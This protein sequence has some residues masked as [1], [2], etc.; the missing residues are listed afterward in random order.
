MFPASQIQ[1]LA[2]G[3][4]ALVPLGWML[5]MS[6]GRVS[7]NLTNSLAPA[8]V[9]FIVCGITPLAFICATSALLDSS[10]GQALYR[11]SSESPRSG[12]SKL[13][14]HLWLPLWQVLKTA[15]PRPSYFGNPWSAGEVG[16]TVILALCNI[17]W[18]FVPIVVRLNSKSHSHGPDQ[19]P[20]YK[21]ARSICGWAGWAGLWDAGLCILFV[22]RENM[23]TK[24][25]LGSEAGQYHRV[26]RFHIGLGYTSFLMM[27]LHSLF[28]L[29][30]FIVKNTFAEEMFP[31]V[32]SMGYWNFA[33]L[34]SW[35]ALVGMVATSVYKVRRSNYRVFYWT[36]QL[37][38][39]FFFFAFV[40]MGIMAAYPVM[41]PC[42][43]FIYDRLRP[44][45]LFKRSTEAYIEKT[46]SDS[47]V[48]VQV[49]I[50]DAWKTTSGYAPGDC[51]ASYY[52]ESPD[53]LTL[54]IKTNGQW[55]TEVAKLC[56][57]QQDRVKVPV[58]IDGPF[59]S[60]STSYL[61]YESLVLVAGGSGVAALLPFVR[62]YAV[63]GP[64]S[65]K[66]HLVWTAKSESDVVTFAQFV[67]DMAD[68]NSLLSS[69]V[70]LSLHITGKPAKTADEAKLLDSNGADNSKDFSS[71]ESKTAANLDSKDLA[72]TV[73]GAEQPV[74]TGRP[75]L[76]PQGR[77]NAKARVADLTLVCVVFLMG[78]LGWYLGVTLNPT[79]D[80]MELCMSDDA[81]KLVG[82]DHFMCW[83]VSPAA[84]AV[85]SVLLASVSG[86]M[87]TFFY[88]FVR[89]HVADSA[90]QVG[91][92]SEPEQSGDLA[93]V[94]WIDH[95]LLAARL[96]EL[97]V[98]RT[99]PD[100]AA[101]LSRFD[102]DAGASG[103]RCA[104]IGAGPERLMRT[105]QY[106]AVGHKNLD[107]QRESW[108]V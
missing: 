35:L 54:L 77:P 72:T 3:T 102:Q 106:L 22:I 23:A 34:V 82:L 52:P 83:Y 21:W 17:A 65:G 50:P 92:L 80:M 27:T 36:H 47:I 18:V 6:P 51:I 40:H 91:T 88:A 30:D 37:Y 63:A 56:P 108:K 94:S 33:G 90:R 64:T 57:D 13:L 98:V 59:G 70:S 60:R 5:Y 46:P 75:S 76:L 29:I 78:I 39:L 73:S 97:D 103:T 42:L 2:I 67:L 15:A 85:L 11:P 100:L 71:V 41:F 43:Y 25:L 1:A 53:R 89:T 104:V 74:G 24:K 49:P 10:L 7:M 48:K 55:T 14:A 84:P 61:E 79:G 16:M 20:A 99:R 31:W 69:R 93:P 38:V 62:H 86:L 45:L 8:D 107:W 95:D 4:L 87:Y 26:V 66:L 32:S 101:I 105:L 68:K 81:F 19:G 12:V 96:A 44:R 58:K 28:F 9:F